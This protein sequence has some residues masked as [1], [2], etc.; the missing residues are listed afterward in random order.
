M[1]TFL[2]YPSTPPSFFQGRYQTAAADA[3]ATAVL[4][5]EPFVSEIFEYMPD[6]VE[7]VRGR[8]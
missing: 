7:T 4:V 8:Y 6:L 5:D 3:T 1:S 2:P